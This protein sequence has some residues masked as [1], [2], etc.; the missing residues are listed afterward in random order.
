MLRLAKVQAHLHGLEECLGEMGE[1]GR[2]MFQATLCASYSL[3]QVFATELHQYLSLSTST[4]KQHQQGISGFLTVP[5]PVLPPSQRRP[6]KR[7]AVTHWDAGQL[8]ELE[9]G[10]RAVWGV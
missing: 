1:E 4:A 5:R 7:R 3:G 6:A 10:G 9:D 8:W 2:T